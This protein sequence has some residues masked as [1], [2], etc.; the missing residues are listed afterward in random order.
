M[1]PYCGERS[2]EFLCNYVDSWILV[3]DMI[4]FTH[5]KYYN[6]TPA[7]LNF[8]VIKELVLQMTV[9]DQAHKELYR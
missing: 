9:L 4:G 5:E 1:K 8:D 7:K 3:L 6:E 2:I